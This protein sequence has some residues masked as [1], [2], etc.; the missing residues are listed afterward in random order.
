MRFSMALFIPL[1]LAALA[2]PAP[3]TAQETIPRCTTVEPLSGKVGT[4]ILV[5]GENLGKAYVAEFYLTDGKN[6]IKLVMTEQT[7]TTIKT[8]I[9][10]SAKVGE[11]YKLMI[12]TK[13]KEP[14][15]I[16]QPV[17]FEVEE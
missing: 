15:L 3:L 11:R 9:P 12:L 10:A 16:E 13:G 4:E 17:R 5:T 7:D 2:A 14:K 1:L 6:D 8:K